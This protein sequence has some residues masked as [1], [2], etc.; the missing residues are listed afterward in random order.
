MRV[1]VL[2]AA[3]MKLTDFWH[4]ALCSLVEVDGLP[5]KRRSTSTLTTWHYILESCQQGITLCH[6]VYIYIYIYIYIVKFMSKNY[7]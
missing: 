6:Y 4:I 2:T 5:L 1:Q 3:R 7:S